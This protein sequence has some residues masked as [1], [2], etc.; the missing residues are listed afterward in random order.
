MLDLN[1]IRNVLDSNSRSQRDADPDELEYL[2]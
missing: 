1:Q 2:Q